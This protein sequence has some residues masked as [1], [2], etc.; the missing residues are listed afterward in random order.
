LSQFLSPYKVRGREI[1]GGYMSL[2]KI[3]AYYKVPG[4]NYI[5]LGI[6]SL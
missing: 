1:E 6:S 5:D 3:K 2:N 4:K